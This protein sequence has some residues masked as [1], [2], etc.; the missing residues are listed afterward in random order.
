MKIASSS[1][2]QPSRSNFVNGGTTRD[3]VAFASRTAARDL[4]SFFEDGVF[5]TR[6]V[7][8]LERATTINDL[9]HGY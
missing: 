9:A 7:G 8:L 4:T 6:W 5:T 2:F 3:F 1:R